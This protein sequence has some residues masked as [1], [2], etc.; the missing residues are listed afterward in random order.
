MILIDIFVVFLKI[1][2]FSFGGGYA[3]LPL[4]MQEV[5][6]NNQWIN[7]EDFINMVSISQITPGPIAINTATFVGYVVHGYKGSFIATFAVVLPSIILVA[8]S[9]KF[10]QKF[11]ENKYLKIFLNSITVVVV[12][13]IGAG[14]ISIF[15]EGVN[16][17]ISILI[18][19]LSF[20]MVTVKKT[21]PIITIVVAGIV[22]AMVL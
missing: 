3:M 13:L 10:I 22:G 8:I 12:G 18:F 6:N 21:N 1:G 14:F 20:Y 5:V 15:I 4:I 7:K 17:I 2:A 11:K 19:A 9:F 16:D